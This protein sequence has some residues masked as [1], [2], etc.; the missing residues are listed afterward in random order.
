MNP[1]VAAIH[2]VT[3]ILH[4]EG[5]L[6]TLVPR[7]ISKVAEPDRALMQQLCYGTLR[8]YPMLSAY[9]GVLLK[10]PFKSKDQDLEAVLACSIYQLL[11]TRIPSHAA[12]NEAVDACKALKKP[13]A[14]GLVNAV[15]RR[16]LREQAQLDSSLEQN[17]AFQTAHPDWLVKLWQE[18]WP[19]HFTTI[20]EANNAQPPMTLRVNQSQND[21]SQYLSLLEKAGIAASAT[22]ASCDGLSLEYPLEVT[23]LPGFLGGAISVQDEAAQLSAHLLNLRADQR[24]L[25][26]CC[27]PGGKTCHI[28]E[29]LEKKYAQSSTVTAI[30]I[31]K[32]RLERVKNN[33]DRLGLEAKLIA[34][35]ALE[36]QDWWDGV[37]FDRILLDAPC[38][39]TGVIRRHPDV[40]LLRKPID[41]DKLAV[42]QL[43][44]LKALWP[45]LKE[46]GVLLYATCSILPQEND[47]VILSF[48]AST[49]EAVVETMD[50]DI[51]VKT[52]SGRQLLP[53]LGGHDGF[54]YARLQKNK[55]L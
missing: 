11:E 36:T 28:L 33:L 49:P 20:I 18:A 43:A 13:W 47:M 37:P 32:K 40:K 10:K 55:K 6:S 34:S 50:L 7:Y 23:Q 53:K 9:L 2:V 27:A 38:S 30:D 42:L 51:G 39:A 35:D 31:S 17:L 3:S 8:Y 44:L 48:V 4:N 41:I 45:L 52:S 1:R 54:Y 15:L 25:D 29:I 12:V 16:F 46:G 5:S 19:E 14:T 26:A 24:I 22:L 21:R